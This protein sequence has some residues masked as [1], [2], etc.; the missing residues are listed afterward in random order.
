VGAGYRERVW[1]EVLLDP[2][3]VVDGELAAQDELQGTGHLH[4]DGWRHWDQRRGRGLVLP[5]LQLAGKSREE[6]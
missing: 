6:Y 4:V 1:T 3:R 5:V 2:H